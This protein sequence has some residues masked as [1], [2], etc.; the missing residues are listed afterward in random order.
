MRGDG[1]GRQ[2]FRPLAFE[3]GALPHANGSCRLKLAQTEVL[4]GVKAE[5]SAPLGAGPDAGRV[6]FAVECSA[7]AAAELVGSSSASSLETWTSQTSLMLERFFSN[8]DVLDLKSLS[9]IA[10]K[11]C[12]VLFVDVLVLSSDGNV[13]DA[14]ALGAHAALYNTRLPKVEVVAGE[15]GELSLEL[16]DDPHDTIRLDTA[17]LPVAVTLGAVGSNVFVDPSREEEQASGASLTVAVGSGARVLGTSKR[18]LGTLTPELCNDMMLLALHTGTL[19]L[20]TLQTHLPT[21]DV[22]KARHS[23]LV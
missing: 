18:G 4:V 15:D 16:S 10:G 11:Q 1:R 7:G 21:A 3:L 22:D 23:I 6:Q 8:S 19:L 9:I 2:D 20:Q 5:I 14:A 12:W 13:A 17:R